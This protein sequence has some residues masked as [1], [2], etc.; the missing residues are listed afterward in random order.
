MFYVI[1]RG[2]TLVVVGGSLKT[3]VPEFGQGHISD[4][5]L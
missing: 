3:C 1:Y 4:W 5:L 2:K